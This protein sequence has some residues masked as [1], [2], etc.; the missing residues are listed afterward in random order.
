MLHTPH[1]PGA[2]SVARNAQM[3]PLRRHS[4]SWRVP[5]K[6]KVFARG[7]SLRRRVAYSLAIVR[8]VLV[9]VVLLA[10]YYLFAMGRIVD[11][12]VNVDAQVATLAE[13]ASIDMLNARRAEL[14]YFLLRDP[15]D[16]KLSRDNLSQLK[17]TLRECRRLLPEEDPLLNQMQSKLV[18][19]E[20]RLNQAVTHM[21]NSGATQREQL[22][23]VV[24]A[25]ERN[26]NDLLRRSQRVS[27]SSLMD[28]LRNEVGSFDLQVANTLAAHDPALRQTT[29]GLQTT[30]NAI[31]QLSAQLEKTSWDRV[32]VDHQHARNLVRRAEWV[33]SI[34][35]VL[36]LVVSVLVSFILPRQVVKPLV[37]LKTAVDHA[38][39][40]NYEIE[41]DVEGQGEVVQL[42][43]SVRSLIA[44][45]RKAMHEAGV[46]RPS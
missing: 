46:N 39:A 5:S 2:D 28:Q 23:V 14:N 10:V 43:N 42:A 12:I 34:V 24:N 37:D 17:G 13:N 15:D 31:L 30:G 21:D 36:T 11:R 18:T 1:N 29:E 9:P 26:L 6:L 7:A 22:Q 16:L 4:M 38:A 25:Y 3:T 45:V 33:L 35:S 44:S 8:L 19:Y 20:S 32:Q 41:F 27:R 40:G